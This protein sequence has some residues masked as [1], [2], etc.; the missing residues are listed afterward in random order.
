VNKPH[1][2]NS[3]K[4]IRK[5]GDQNMY[6]P[7][8][9]EENVRR[10]YFLKLEKKKPMTRLLDHI[11]NEYFEQN[12]DEKQTKEGGKSLCMSVKSAETRSKSNGPKRAESIMTSDTRTAHSAEP[13][14]TP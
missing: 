14:T 6:H 9:S 8:M 3:L 12:T 10:L 13:S 11:L 4:H 1:S 7:A 5:K 2:E